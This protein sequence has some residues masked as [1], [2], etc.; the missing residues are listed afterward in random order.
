[1]AR[2]SCLTEVEQVRLLRDWN[3]AT[4]DRLPS[5]GQCVHHLFEQQVQ[6]TPQALA[7]SNGSQRLTYEQLNSRAN[8]QARLLQRRGIGP[9]ALV[10]LCLPRS[11]DLVI[12]LLAILKAGAAYVPL[13]PAYPRERLAFTVQDAHLALILT[14]S[15]LADQL[16]LPADLALCLDLP[17]LAQA[18]SSANLAREMSNEHLAYVIYTSGSTGRP[19]GVCISHRSSVIFLTWVRQQFSDEELAGVLFGT[20]ICF[21][22]SIFE[23]FAPLSWGGKAILASTVLD[24]PLLA[25]REQ[26]TLLNTVPSAA[27]ALLA[28]MTLPAG[29]RTVNLAGE[30]LTR[31]LV[32]ALYRQPGVKRVCNLYGPTEDTTYSTW[33]ALDAQEQGAVS[34]GR[35]LENTQAYIVDDSLQ[36]VPPGVIG[37][38]YLGGDGQA[39]G[40]LNRPDLTAE[41]FIPDPFSSLPGRRLYKTGDLARYRLDGTIEYI[42][43]VDHQVKI[44]GFRIELGEIEASLRQHPAVAD[45]V[46]VA[47]GEQA[48]EKR[49]VAYIVARPSYS[50]DPSLLR[51]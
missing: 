5:P 9:E 49:L 46:V 21:D 13:D 40:Y 15:E 44:R 8:Q 35:P 50:L 36:P 1:L 19:K 4:L 17:E 45:A 3:A 7:L 16:A 6:R 22:L 31:D 48:G 27:A 47:W 34:I 12:G 37:E 29:L 2:L 24:L 43:R 25:A 32:Q 39:R 51:D 20:S 30:A 18:E 38:L 26:I 14:T 11:F 33:V 23:L 28:N 42:G 41:R 10:G